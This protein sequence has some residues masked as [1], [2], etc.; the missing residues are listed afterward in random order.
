MAE[1]DWGLAK[2][3]VDP[4]SA[5]VGGLKTGTDLAQQ[6]K[7][8]Q[9]FQGYDPENPLPTVNALLQVGA[10]PEA[11]AVS[12]IAYQTQQR[13][14]LAMGMN[15]L[16]NPSGALPAAPAAT[17]VSGSSP[18]AAP[19]PGAPSAPQAAAQPDPASL[20]PDQKAH[21]MQ[22]ADTFDQIGV[23]LAGLP[24]EQRKAALAAETPALV[25]RG[26]PA[27]Q[28]SSFDP[29][30]D[31]IAMVHQQVAQ[32]RGQLSAPAAGSAPVVQ[33]PGAPGEA[34]GAPAAAPAQSAPAGGPALDLRNPNTQRSLEAMA[35]GGGN[36]DPLV[37]L[38]TATM[39]KYDA[40]R[41][42]LVY[43]ER[44][45]KF[46]NSGPNEQG[47]AYDIDP[48][49]GDVI[50]AHNVPG[51]VEASATQ[52][53]TKAAAEA[54]GK[55]PY[56]GATSR[57][58]AGGEGAGKAPFEMVH[59]KMPADATHPGGYEADMTL[60]Q[61]KAMGGGAAPGAGAGSSAGPGAEAFAKTDADAYSKT[62]A[63]V[64]DPTTMIGYQNKAQVAQQAVNA[65]MAIN[66]NAWTPG[67]KA[68]ANAL[69]VVGLDSKKAN[70]LSYY[71]S[72]I[73]QVTRGSFATFPRL[74]KEFELVKDA[75]PSLKTPRDAAALTFASIA[76]T[77]NRNAAYSRF[78]TQYDGP[79]SQRA[80]N[81]AWL[82]NPQSQTS[83]FADPVFK[84]LTIDGKPAVYVNPTP[85]PNGHVYGVFRPGSANAQT[86]LVH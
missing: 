34:Q 30:D 38:G 56:V 47:I 83:L 73:P 28:I 70:D 4:V 18:A 68:V 23:Q 39:P 13:K 82:A 7:A 37:A 36:I 52:V 29:T 64:G 79:P 24:Y 50:G 10:V 21:A 5:Y 75:I 81:K 85:A 45:G 86:F 40:T 84:N 80:L 66:P 63:T 26:L 48:N 16:I 41:S 72:L 77:N 25:A 22:T 51:Y 76:A 44:T 55:L 19:A 12:N 3:G 20:T 60:A 32:L 35:L 57:A 49:T 46:T 61:F 33:V 11:T 43:D 54:A 9:A 71:S 2:P 67:S 17:P 53:G 62:L 69:N 59:V 74:E 42:G 78:A 65:A 58:E 6:A 8:R 14:L 15:G 1:I 27:D 31:N